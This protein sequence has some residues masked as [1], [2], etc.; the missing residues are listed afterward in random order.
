MRIKRFDAYTIGCALTA[1]E[2]SQEGLYV[3]DFLEQ[4]AA[5]RDFI[6]KIVLI[7]AVK[8]EVEPPLNP[9]SDVA[10][11]PDEK[12]IMIYISDEGEAG[13]LRTKIAR[14]KMERDKGGY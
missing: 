4:N 14:Y 1:E 11:I 6:E 5:A 9:I 12:G 8:E 10:V 7:V 2:L 3:K 13:I